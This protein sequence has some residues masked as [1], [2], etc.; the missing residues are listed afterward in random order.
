[1]ATLDP[2]K[3]LNNLLSKG[4]QQ[5]NKNH[6]FLRFSV[7]GKMV[8]HTKISHNSGDLDNY[9]IKSMASQCK[10]T[11]SQFIDLA[12]CPLPG[13]EYLNILEKQGFLN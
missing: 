9:L 5:D 13:Q 8:L 6:K 12:Q 11:K 3:T 7:K 4:F 10:L 2:R 1:M